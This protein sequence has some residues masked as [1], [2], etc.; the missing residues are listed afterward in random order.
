MCGG[1]DMWKK[2]L[3]GVLLIALAML[4]LPFALVGGWKGEKE[5]GKSLKSELAD[6]KQAKIDAAKGLEGKSI[7]VYFHKEEKVKEVPLFSYISAVVA[8]EMPVSY[9]E[10]ALKAQAVAALS[11]T[12]CKMEKELSSPGVFPEHK[13]AYV[14]TDPSHCK[15]YLSEDELYQK[16]GD[17]YDANLFKIEKLCARSFRTGYGVGGGT[18]QR[19]VPRFFLRAYRKRT[20]GVGRGA[21]LPSKRG[22]LL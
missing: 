16:W 12:M 6:L 7:K 5:D 3:I 8:A 13:G 15:A 18:H 14:C 1:S 11:Y 4:F 10:E 9:E 19:G 17:D 22:Q 21:F 2:I 20:R